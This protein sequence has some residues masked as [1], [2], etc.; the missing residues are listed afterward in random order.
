MTVLK[1]LKEIMD[2][3]YKSNREK[4]KAIDKILL[5]DPDIMLWIDAYKEDTRTANKDKAQRVLLSVYRCF[6]G[7]LVSQ[8]INLRLTIR[9]LIEE[10]RED[11]SHSKGQRRI[12]DFYKWLIG[13]HVQGYAPRPEPVSLPSARTYSY[14]RIRGWYSAHNI[15]FPK[16]LKA[17]KESGG[18]NV[19][20][21]DRSVRV[22]QY[23]GKGFPQLYME[24]IQPFFNQLKTREQ[25]LMGFMLTG[26]GHDLIDI[27]KLK[28]ETIRDSN[29]YLESQSYFLFS[30]VRQK[31]G[32]SFLCPI[33]K[34]A[35]SLL[36]KYVSQHFTDDDP[37]ETLVF[38]RLP[39]DKNNNRNHKELSPTIVSFNFKKAAIDAG[40]IVEEDEVTRR[41]PRKKKREYNPLRPKRMRHIFKTIAEKYA[42]KHNWKP[43]LLKYFMGHNQSVSDNYS[44]ND[45]EAILIEYKKIEPYLSVEAVVA[46]TIE[47]TRTVR[48][49]ERLKDIERINKILIERI[50]TTEKNLADVT[51]IWVRPMMR[52]AFVGNSEEE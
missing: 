48:M 32:E 29:N 21:T 37:D 7:F 25:V 19:A 50:E 1:D 43:N 24:T 34:W 35:T 18:T 40:F 16:T 46:G 45:A 26:G 22:I 13:I 49:E 17:P 33:S 28:L 9:N 42:E 2:K 14:A 51:R 20:R 39:D 36:D 3:E 6:V 11:E 12:K 5:A 15:R 38:Q 41:D 23:D 47:A 8:E 30:G 44:E 27:L 31:T 4:N 52:D 10:A